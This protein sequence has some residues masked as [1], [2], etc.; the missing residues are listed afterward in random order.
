VTVDFVLRAHNGAYYLASLLSQGLDPY[1][2][3]PKH[4]IMDYHKWFSTKLNS[5]WAV[6]DV[7]CGNGAL[8]RDLIKHCKHMIAIDTDPNKVKEAKKLNT[9]DNIEFI[10]GDATTYSFEEHF[11]AV[12]LSNVLEHIKDRV[13]FL[14]S[15]SQYCDVLLI[16]VPMIDRD[17]ITLFKKERGIP[18]LLDSDHY[19]E[20]SLDTFSNEITDAGLTVFEHRVKYGELY[21][22]C[23]KKE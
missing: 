5:N 18:Y 23:S 10:V 20:Y 6:L 12:I 19:I 13:Q 17:W 3:H 16:R 2:L 1:G 22:V 8:T 14:E 4:R 9:D 11:D 21:S 15:I 7:G